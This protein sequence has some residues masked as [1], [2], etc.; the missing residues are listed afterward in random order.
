M[1]AAEL[2]VGGTAPT[3]DDGPGL[4]VGG[5]PADD[6]PGLAMGEAP[7]DDGLG[8]AVGEAPADDWPGLAVGEAPAATAGVELG[9][10]ETPGGRSFISSRR[11]P[12]GVLPL[13]A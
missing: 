10:G 13:C 1:G 8:L 3:V 11:S 6:G 9:V 12:L 5:A 4:A 2:L 7:A